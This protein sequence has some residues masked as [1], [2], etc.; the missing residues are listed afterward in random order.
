[1]RAHE[2]P[3]VSDVLSQYADT[4]PMCLDGLKKKSP[5][6]IDVLIN[7]HHH[8]DHTAGNKAFRPAVKK[9]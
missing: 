3:A 1:M 4:A 8:G 9:V 2:S 6:T 5:H 7:T